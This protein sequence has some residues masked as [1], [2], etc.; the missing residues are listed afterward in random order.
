MGME[1]PYE[2]NRQGKKKG[3]ILGRPFPRKRR[4]LLGR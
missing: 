2:R 4:L 3:T 1:V